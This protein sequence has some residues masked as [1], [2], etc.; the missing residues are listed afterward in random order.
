[1]EKNIKKIVIIGPEST[2]KSSLT[3]ALADHYKTIWV[4]EFAREY[5]EKNGADYTF[6]NLYEIAVGQIKAEEDGITKVIAT[7]KMQNAS[8]LFIDTDLHVIKIWSEYVFNKCD[9]RL[10]T[11]ITKREY[12]LYLLCDID[13]PWVKDDLREYPDVKV[14]QKLFH[15]YK[16]EMAAQ[17]TPWKVIR[18]N[19]KERLADALKFTDQILK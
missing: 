2:G 6:E 5:L 15:Y 17:K 9:N 13:L 7:S 3:K 4:K 8:L 18:G 12:D 16:E 11:E 19:Y 1:M 14:R 10:L